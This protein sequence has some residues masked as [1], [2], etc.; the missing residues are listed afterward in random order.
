MWTSAE[1][2]FPEQCIWQNKVDVTILLKKKKIN[3]FNVKINNGLK[4][5]L[6]YLDK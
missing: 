6:K 2:H 5:N 4:R 1:A 3:R